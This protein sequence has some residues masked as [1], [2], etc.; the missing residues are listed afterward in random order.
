[1][2]KCPRRVSAVLPCR[3]VPDEAIDSNANAPAIDWRERHRLDESRYIQGKCKLAE[4]E[5][6]S[7]IRKTELQSRRRDS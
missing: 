2:E 1:M 6:H 3:K 5:V 7:R 4:K